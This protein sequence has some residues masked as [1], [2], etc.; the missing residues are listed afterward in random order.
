[1]RVALI[2]NDL[3]DN[4]ISADSIERAQMFYPE[5]ECIEAG[6]L[7]PGFIRINGEFVQPTPPEHPKIYKISRLAFMNRFTDLEAINIDMAS[8]GETLAAATLRRHLSKVENAEYIDLERADTRSGVL[9]ME[10]FGLLAAGRALEILN[11][12]AAEH[13]IFKGAV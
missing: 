9:A 10:E 12:P 8:R 1:M 4:V 6:L 2:K 5:H 3:V 7:G 11:T 13:E